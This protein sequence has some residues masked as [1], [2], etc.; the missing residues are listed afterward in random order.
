MIVANFIMAFLFLMVGH[1][2][3]IV[4]WELFISTYERSSRRLLMRSLSI[5]YL[6]NFILPFRLGDIFRAYYA[7]KKMKN[8]I[9]FSLATVIMD[10][11]LDIIAV[12]VI[13]FCFGL[14]KTEYKKIMTESAAFYGLFSIFITC[15]LAVM[16]VFR[17]QVKNFCKAICSVFNDKIKLDGLY[18]FWSLI[19]TFKDLM[20]INMGKLIKNTIL[21][22]VS[23]LFSYWC[24]ALSLSELGNKMTTFDL[25]TILFSRG[26]L[27]VTSFSVINL[28]E[29]LEL[30]AKVL[31]FTYMLLPLIVLIGTSYIS[32]PL[33]DKIIEKLAL[34]IP[35]NKQYL[36]LLPQINTKDQL[37]FLEQYFSSKKRDY[38]SAFIELNRNISIIQDFSAGSNATT[39]LCMSRDCTFYRKY[40]F[41]DD[42]E[43]LKKQIKWIEKNKKKL[44]LCNIVYKEYRE[45]Y[46]C[47]DMEYE[48][49]AIS[50]FRYVHSNQIE[51]SK[52]ILK[53]VLD[54][55]HNSLYLATKHSANNE[56]V[57]CY[58]Q[59]KV[60]ENLKTI[61]S[62]KE[63]Q[64]I[65]SYNN[66][67]IN[68]QVCKNLNRLLGL[69]DQ[70]KLETLFSSD[71]CC[72]IHGD[73]TIENIIC[74]SNELE[75]SKAF[76]IIDPNTDNIHESAFLD[77]GK[78]LQSL[79]G[80]YEFLM[81]TK[82]VNVEQDRI[83]FTFT[84]SKAYDELFE[85][86]IEYLKKKFTRAELKSIFFHEI[87]HWLRLL[88]YKIKK[89]SKKAVL[90]YAGFILICNDINTWYEEE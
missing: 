60:V 51:K 32:N 1:F 16:L 45:N 71:F 66:I 44:P 55:F 2:F 59:K 36:S 22:W 39:M 68:G 87:V 37:I 24:L 89:D 57:K 38:L 85:F 69:F 15:I 47:Y 8:G 82:A 4:R 31:M 43:K 76:Y 77:Y 21:M 5:S 88:P 61:Q 79:H 41:G 73:L 23:Y 7:G 46:S 48:S 30:T 9:G 6:L 26:S 10:R 81:L 14:M 50:M 34:T 12:T 52:E 28:M 25:F 78:L 27:D 29:G 3:K 86:L 62:A 49:N 13:F 83:D 74:Y 18:F 70:V 33:L 56:L 40:A 53:N 67:I 17:E 58:I 65:L 11:F 54:V 90:F 42:G 20:K 35:D 75:I 63:F 80:G 84:K 72:E 64:E 19:S